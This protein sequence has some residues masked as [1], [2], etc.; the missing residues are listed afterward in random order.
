MKFK[1]D[2]NKVWSVILQL[3]YLVILN[4]SCDRAS[5][6]MDTLKRQKKTDGQTHEL[7]LIS[8][9]QTGL[10]PITHY[11]FFAWILGFSGFRVIFIYLT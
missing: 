11:A 2:E 8:K 1:T 6:K 4:R 9:S 3:P 10:R 5:E 7:Q